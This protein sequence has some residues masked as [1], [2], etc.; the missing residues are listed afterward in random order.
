LNS[1]SRNATSKGALWMTHCAACEFDKLFDDIGES[2]L[3]AQ[4]FPRHAVNIGSADVDLALRI[5]IKMEVA[6][7]GSAVD[8]FDCSDLDDSVAKL[9]IEPGRFGVENDLAHQK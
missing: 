9:R 5:E 2:R 1:S 4:H 3:A 7:G 8:D 6:P